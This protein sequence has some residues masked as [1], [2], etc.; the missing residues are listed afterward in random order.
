MYRS[1]TLFNSEHLHDKQGFFLLAELDLDKKCLR[2][3]T[4]VSTVTNTLYI[5]GVIVTLHHLMTMLWYNV[6]DLLLLQNRI[7][8]LC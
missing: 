6:R 8:S 1:L 4:I 7:W 5:N 3:L 2:W